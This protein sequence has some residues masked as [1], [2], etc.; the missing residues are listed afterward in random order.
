MLEQDFIK[1]YLFGD[2]ELEDID[3][4]V[5]YWHTHETHILLK[6]VGTP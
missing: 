3:S 2:A 1:E 4:Y 6:R 5:E